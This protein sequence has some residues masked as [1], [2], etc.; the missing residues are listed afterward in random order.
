MSDTYTYGEYYMPDRLPDEIR[1]LREYNKQQ[2]GV[3][4]ETRD[5]ARGLYNGMYGVDGKNGFRRE[6]RNYQAETRA[7]IKAL[8][9]KIDKLV[10]KIIGAVS[11]IVAIIVGI[12]KL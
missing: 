6:L 5:L 8:N 1:E 9:A 2:D 10:P 12:S 4:R 7:E 11:A 3:I